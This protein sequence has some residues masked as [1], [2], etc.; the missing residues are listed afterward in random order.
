[1]K[2]RYLFNKYISYFVILVVAFSCFYFFTVD[3]VSN[4]AFVT[5]IGIDRDDT[6]YYVVYQMFAPAGKN[7]TDNVNYPI[8]TGR[9]DSLSTAMTDIKS[10][11]NRQPS[12]DTCSIVVLGKN[13]YENDILSSIS[14]L[15][16]KKI[17]H[18][19]LVVGAENTALDIFKT[20]I[21]MG[22]YVATALNKTFKSQQKTPEYSI[23]SIR[24]IL[25]ESYS[26]TGVTSIPLIKTTKMVDDYT[27]DIS[28]T[29]EENNV[30]D[31]DNNQE[32]ANKEKTL[33]SCDKTIVLK[34]GK[35]ELVLT[36]EETVG[37]N[38]FRRKFNNFTDELDGLEEEI[39]VFGT[40]ARIAAEIRAKKLKIDYDL[41]DTNVELKINLTVAPTN[42]QAISTNNKEEYITM[43][44]IHPSENVLK[45]CEKLV[46][47]YFEKVMQRQLSTTVDFI[48]VYLSC[49]S[50]YGKKWKDFIESNPD[51]IQKVNYSI[52]VKCE[53]N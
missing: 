38:M 45:G 1:M 6:S 23:A 16:N 21:P 30:P 18:R 7:S 2:I 50:K 9:G 40:E 14:S 51:Y 41:T 27:T 49:Y 36:S 3:N 31:I 22:E 13:V 42:L 15:T 8:I 19:T 43:S 47:Q 48:D 26:N 29:N 34:D 10:R 20:E 4:M 53:E 39:D 44:N 35:K 32:Q 11:L 17:A 24:T 46:S 5:G 37:F 33:F 12:L 25:R 52:N 28:T